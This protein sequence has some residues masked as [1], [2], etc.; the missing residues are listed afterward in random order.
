MR[1]PEMEYPIPNWIVITRGHPQGGLIF[2]GCGMVRIVDLIRKKRDGGEHTPDELAYLVAGI[3]DG[4]ILDYQLSAWL[5]AVYFQGMSPRETRELSCQMADSGERVDLS[6]I[7]G[8]KI[9]KHSTGG[10]GD[11]VSIVL[12]PLV[13][14]AG[15][16]VCK[17]SGRGLGHTGGTI[18]KL[19]SIPG[20]RTDLLQETL[21]E[22]VRRIGIGLV[23]QSEQLVPADKRLYALRDVTGTVES[24]PLI[25]ASIMSKKLAGGADG[26]L[27]DVKVGKGAFMKNQTDAKALGELMV[28]IGKGAGKKVVAVLSNMDQPLGKAIGNSLEVREAIA[29]L[30]NEGPEDLRELCLTLGAQMLLLAEKENSEAAAKERLERILSSGKGLEVFGKWVQ[31]QGGDPKVIEKPA[32]LPRAPVMRQVLSV[33]RGFVSRIDTELLGWTA[34]RLGACRERKGEEIDPSVGLVIFK[35]LGERVEKG[36]ALAEAYTQ[37]EE[38]AIYAEKQV[39]QSIT[40]SDSDCFSPPLVYGYIY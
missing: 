33:E 16:P 5:M 21:F 36:E 6:K 1:L 28:S 23:A 7:P 37:T 3:T 20:F 15:A 2:K 40:I 8:I 4:T 35:K 26:F 31:A 34:G 14:A 38:A 12:A 27:L 30:K 25:A 22:Q 24:I 13:A 17:M 39:L 29:V 11:K 19:E 18:D 10:V 9:D 32:L